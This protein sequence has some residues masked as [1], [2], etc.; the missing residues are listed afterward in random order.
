[1]PNNPCVPCCWCHQVSRQGAK[2]AASKEKDDATGGK[3]SDGEESGGEGSGVPRVGPRQHSLLN[4]TSAERHAVV[5]DEVDAHLKPTDRVFGESAARLC[6]EMIQYGCSLSSVGP[7]LQTAVRRS[8]GVSMHEELKITFSHK[9]VKLL[10]LGITKLD[11]DELVAAIMRAPFLCV[12]ADESMRNVDKKNPLFVSFWDVEADAPW[13]GA[14]RIC[15]MKDKTA[16][17]Q[18]Q[19]FYETIV[20]VLKYPLERVLYVLSDNTASVSEKGGC[21]TLLQRK[22]RGEDMTQNTRTRATRGGRGGATASGGGRGA[23]RRRG[24][25]SGGGRGGRS[26]WGG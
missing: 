4:L 6:Q 7:M 13:W 24:G 26:R 23:A 25:A 19:L 18:A 8:T 9:T 10:A 16:E 20:D 22:F 5:L 17:T 14:F 11:G 15:I 21:V 2:L 1:M 3:G 12:A